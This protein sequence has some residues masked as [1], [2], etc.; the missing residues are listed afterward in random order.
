[1]RAT[2]RIKPI[3]WILALSLFSMLS[4]CMLLEI[5][6][7]DLLGK[8]CAILPYG[9]VEY[10]ELRPNGECI[11]EILLEDK[12]PLIAHGKWRYNQKLKS[13]SLDGTRS[14]L[15]P[16]GKLNPNIEQILPGV[17]RGPAVYRSFFGKVI[18]GH[19]EHAHFE[20]SDLGICPMIPEY[21]YIP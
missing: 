1:M 19:G 21:K 8:Y 7:Q 4:G 5:T 13:L 9:G 12:E 17:T 15:A 14:A 10:L 3:V 6:E 11:Q 16:F 2:T 20:K 18:I